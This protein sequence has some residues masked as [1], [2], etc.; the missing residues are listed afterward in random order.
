MIF[1]DGKCLSVEACAHQIPSKFWQRM[2]LVLTG[3]K[4]W[5]YVDGS[6]SI[7]SE[8]RFDHIPIGY[9]DLRW[10]WRFLF[11]KEMHGGNLQTSRN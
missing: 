4:F 11:C 8:A 3:A 9:V 1:Q 10:C 7:G 5:M 6:T 2:R